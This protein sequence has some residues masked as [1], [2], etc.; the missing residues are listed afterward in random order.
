MVNIDKRRRLTDGQLESD[1][2]IKDHLRSERFKDGVSYVIVT[3][4]YLG[5]FALVVLF[6]IYVFHLVDKGDWDKV[7][8]ILKTAITGAIGYAGGYFKKT[9]DIK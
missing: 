9:L 1:K 7:E 8:L 5:A 3:A 2:K 4:M 6:A